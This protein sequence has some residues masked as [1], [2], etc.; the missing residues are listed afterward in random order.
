MIRMI[1]IVSFLAATNALAVPPPP[2]QVSANC[3]NPTYASDVL[4]CEDEELL[5]L[6]LAIAEL[7]AT[8]TEPLA[9]EIESDQDWFRRSR[10]CAVAEDHRACLLQAYR[11]RYALIYR[12]PV[13]ED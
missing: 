3:T 5:E 1:F 8:R 12:S 6:D 7:I 11:K 4:V 10:L 2:G 9:P 13:S